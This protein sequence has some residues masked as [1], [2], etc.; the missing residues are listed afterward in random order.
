MNQEGYRFGRIV[1]LISKLSPLTSHQVAEAAR[2]PAIWFARN[3]I[4][5]YH[6]MD[7]LGD[8]ATGETHD[9]LVNKIF[10]QYREL[11]GEMSSIPKRFDADGTASFW[12]GWQHAQ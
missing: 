1:A 7:R 12:L 8:E 10:H 6:A 11:V 2:Q 3:A 5:V 9:P 4:R